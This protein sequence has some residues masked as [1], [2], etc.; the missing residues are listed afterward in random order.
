MKPPSRSS[1]PVQP[2]ILPS[3]F[4]HESRRD[5]RTFALSVLLHLCAAVFVGLLL[6]HAATHSRVAESLPFMRLDPGKMVFTPSR[7][8]Q[9]GMNGK[10][11]GGGQQE[12]SLP[13]F[14]VPP[15]VVVRPIAPPTTHVPEVAPALAVPQGITNSQI[16]TILKGAVGD[17]NG[18]HG[19]TSDGP[20]SN[21]GIGIGRNGGIGSGN[22]TGYDLLTPGGGVS[23]PRVIYDPEPEYTEEAR[24][25]KHQ[26][27]VLLACVVGADGRVHDARVQHALGLG[28]D[29]KA[30]EA[31]KKWKFEPSR[32]N[33]QPVAVKIMVEVN[34]RMY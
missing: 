15:P 6:H 11:T 33:G 25:L 30:I 5:P 21:G 4:P 29:E 31:V 24:R 23:M 17:P 8:P 9:Q 34:F 7:S 14:G 32:Y 20:G 26:G 18:V 22:H 1:S 12:P 10:D 28:L 2:D 13:S 27:N 19:P 16:T 3:L